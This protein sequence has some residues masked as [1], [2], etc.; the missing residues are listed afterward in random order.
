M[1][2]DDPL[3]RLGTQVIRDCHDPFNVA[4]RTA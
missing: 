3:V 4:R 2:T 1:N